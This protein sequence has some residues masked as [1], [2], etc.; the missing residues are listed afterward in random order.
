MWLHDEAPEKDLDQIQQ[1]ATDVSLFP[2]HEGTFFPASFGHLL[3]GYDAGYYGYLWSEVYGDDM[4][5]RFDDEGVDN[6]A[7]GREYRRAILE[8]GGSVD[9]MM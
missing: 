4:W 5:S 6:P 7:V 3:S 2:A 8:K 9:G 1:R